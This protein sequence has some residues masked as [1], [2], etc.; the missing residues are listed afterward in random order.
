MSFFTYIVS[1]MAGLEVESTLMGQ[2][3]L[4]TKDRRYESNDSREIEKGS[5]SP[6]LLRVSVE[7]REDMY[8]RGQFPLSSVGDG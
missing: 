4:H 7:L 1:M 6:I 2:E 5:M 3:G 8:L